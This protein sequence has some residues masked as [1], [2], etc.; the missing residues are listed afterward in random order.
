[1]K[2]LF[3]TILIILDLGAILC[4]VLAYGPNKKFRTF[5]VTTAMST[6]HHKY[7]ARTIYSE[8]T[9]NKVLSENTLEEINEA[10]NLDAI[11]IGTY[12]TENF[13]SKEEEQILKKE[14]SDIYKYFSYKEGSN[15][16][17]I[18]VI[19]DPSRI[20]LALT[21]KPGYVGET[22]KTISK[23]NNGIVAI[24]ASGFMDLNEN[25]DGSQATG[26]VIKNGK[27]IWQGSPNRWG[28]GLIGFNKD[29]KLVL[30]NDSPYAA[31]KNGMM[32]A[33]TFGPFLIVNGKEANVI[34]NGGSGTHPR[35][36]IAQRQD[37]IV[38]FIVIDGNGNKKG[39]RGGVSYSEMIKILK[40]YNAYNAANLDGGASSIM[41]INNEIVNNPV[42][43]GATGERRHPNAWIVK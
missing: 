20:S 2:K 36:I 3:I 40:K 32:D 19:Y 27:L 17:H 33:V 21:S 12:K 14:D 4:L 18:A 31:I 30:T 43:Y 5:L 6:M 25:G 7:L 11:K 28:N 23:N 24:N 22:V 29:N 26:N 41:V 13:E 1:M 16:V 34:G 8:R 37:G 15:T 9:I 39:Y 42:G 10:T 38:L 35:T